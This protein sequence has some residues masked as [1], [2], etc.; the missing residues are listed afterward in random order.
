MRA[1]DACFAVKF[2]HSIVHIFKPRPVVIYYM[3]SGLQ[4]SMK[5]QPPSLSAPVATGAARVN[6]SEQ[7]QSAF[8]VSTSGFGD[9]QL[10]QSLPG[11]PQQSRQ[12]NF[13]SPFAEKRNSRLHQ[14]IPHW[15]A[16]PGLKRDKPLG[17]AIG[18]LAPRRGHRT[19][20]SLRR[21]HQYLHE[22]TQII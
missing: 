5:T 7:Q 20:G 17:P 3:T 11:N 15:R 1:R 2:A 16:R 4:K 9:Q 10:M 12:F 13:V 18:R 22:T 14:L 19:Q 6:P 21:L 8:G